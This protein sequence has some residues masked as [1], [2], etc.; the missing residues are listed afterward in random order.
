MRRR[1]RPPEQRQAESRGEA[2]RARSSRRPPGPAIR[3]RSQTP[4]ARPDRRQPEA[5]PT[6][7]RPVVTCRSGRV[8]ARRS[9]AYRRTRRSIRRAR[10]RAATASA[11]NP[12]CSAS[13]LSRMWR[14]PARASGSPAASTARSHSVSIPIE[15]C[16]K[17]ADPMRAST[18]S[19][20]ITFEWTNVGTSREREAVGYTSRRRLYVVRGDQLPERAV[21]KRSHRGFFKPAMA[22]LR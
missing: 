19:T 7:V 6:A 16:E 20:I 5:P 13:S 15:R 10:P 17:L 4:R 8:C 12:R 1:S 14:M 21:A 11:D 9:L 22:F 3:P 18:S 2:D